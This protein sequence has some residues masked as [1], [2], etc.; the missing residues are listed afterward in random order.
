MI[1]TILCF[2]NHFFFIWSGLSLFGQQISRSHAIFSAFTSAPHPGIIYEV[3]PITTYGACITVQYN[4]IHVPGTHLTVVIDY[5]EHLSIPVISETF[6]Y[7][8]AINQ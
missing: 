2:I 5:E 7:M 8:D 6:E 1:I 3:Q 4:E